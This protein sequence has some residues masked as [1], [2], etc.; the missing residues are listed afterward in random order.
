MNRKS[1]YGEYGEL[2]RRLLVKNYHLTNKR[3]VTG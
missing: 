2:F 1:E 3:E